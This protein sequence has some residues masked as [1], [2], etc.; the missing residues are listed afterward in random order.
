MHLTSSGQNAAELAIAYFH[1]RPTDGA[2]FCSSYLSPDGMAL[3]LISLLIMISP[4]QIAAMAAKLVPGGV[5]LIGRGRV[6][7]T[8]CE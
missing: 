1:N 4:M 2:L 6:R 5:P 3:L 8:S 7:A